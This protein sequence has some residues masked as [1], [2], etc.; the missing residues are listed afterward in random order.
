LVLVASAPAVP[1]RCSR[2]LNS[3]TKSRST[4]LSLGA[5]NSV[6]AEAAPGIGAGSVLE[7]VDDDV[8]PTAG[9]CLGSAHT[10]SHWARRMV[11]THS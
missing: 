4:Y 1:D 2:C 11:S 9:E 3:L 6:V 7:V 8:H 5:D 10:G